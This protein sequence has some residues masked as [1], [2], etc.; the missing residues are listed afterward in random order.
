MANSA[1]YPA[2]NMPNGFSAAGTPTNAVL[3][4]RPF[5]EAQIIA[6]VKAYQDVAGF[7]LMKPTKMEG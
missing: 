1:G 2:M 5:N 4:G 7:H 3:Y 6:V